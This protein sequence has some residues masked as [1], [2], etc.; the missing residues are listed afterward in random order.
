M[1]LCHMVGCPHEEIPAL[2]AGTVGLPTP[3]MLSAHTRFLS[4]PRGLET[5][6]PRADRGLQGAEED[7]IPH[8]V[9]HQR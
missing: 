1:L 5:A 6:I 8:H 7:A 2:T 9:R 3:S 4:A